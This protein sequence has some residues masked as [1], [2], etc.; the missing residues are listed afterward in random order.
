MKKSRKYD[1]K[2]IDNSSATKPKGMKYC[3]LTDK[4]FKIPVMQ[5]LNVLWENTERQL[6]ETRN[7]LYEQNDFFT[8]EI[9]IIKKN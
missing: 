3:N 2:K 1:T 7:K 4:E 5:K 9:E 6:K 8:K